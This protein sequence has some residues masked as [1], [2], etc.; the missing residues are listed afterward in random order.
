MALRQATLGSSTLLLINDRPDLA[1]LCGADGVHVGQEDLPIDAVRRIVGP[2]RLI[3]VSTHSFE[4]A[5]QAVREGADLIG[6]GPLFPS[7]TKGFSRFLEIDVLR[8]VAE[9]I[10]IPV[11]AIGGMDAARLPEVMAMGIRRAAVGSAITARRDPGPAAAEMV[12]ILQN[13]DRQPGGHPG[14]N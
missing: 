7:R 10:G 13:G 12:A 8:Q 6:I 5:R 14:A 3:G 4:Q 11:F 9:E 1:V 2:D